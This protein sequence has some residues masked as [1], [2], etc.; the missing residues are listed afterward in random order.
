[1]NDADE[2]HEMTTVDRKTARKTFPKT[3]G[4]FFSHQNSV[5]LL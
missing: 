1:M 3:V 5:V 2:T 4:A